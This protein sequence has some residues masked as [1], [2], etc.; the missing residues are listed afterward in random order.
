MVHGRFTVQLTARLLLTSCFSVACTEHYRVGEMDGV[1]DEPK[2]GSG[3]TS[4]GSGTAGSLMTAGQAGSLESGGSGSSLVGGEGP[5]PSKV[6]AGGTGTNTNTSCEVAAE[7]PAA[8]APPFAAPDVVWQRLSLWLYGDVMTP[9]MAMPASTTY[10]WSGQIAMAAF[11]LSQQRNPESRAIRHFVSTAFDL[12]EDATAVTKWTRRLSDGFDP[13]GLLYASSWEGQEHRTGI[14]GEPEWLTRHPRAVS[15]GINILRSVLNQTVPPPPANVD[16]SQIAEAQG[17]LTTRE[18]LEL[19]RTNPVCNACHRL[20]DPL[21][22]SLEHFDV[23]GK[24]RELDSDKPV[25]SSGTYSPEFGGETFTFTSME[26]LGPQL[27]NSCQARWTFADLNFKHALL[28]A[29]LLLEG[30]DITLA[31]QEDLTRV[32]QAFLQSQSYPS[33]IQAIAQSSAFLR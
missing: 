27:A 10:E 13:L 4:S 6:G 29:N 8:P 21:G 24:Y 17:N 28:D 26:D 31:H 1:F 19:H 33:L 14:F 2:A 32:R 22:L 11:Q 7:A 25:D 18:R 12:E 5:S 15:R 30:E 23:E 16:T 9:P 20:I 3:G